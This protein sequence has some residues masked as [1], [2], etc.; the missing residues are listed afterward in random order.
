MN[1]DLQR[2]HFLWD[3][4]RSNACTSDEMDELL[5]ILQQPW[6]QAALD[7]RLYAQ[8]QHADNATVENEPDWEKMLSEIRTIKSNRAKR[9]LSIHWRYAAV[10]SLLII[11][12]AVSYMYR[13]HTIQP[14][15]ANDTLITVKAAPNSVDTLTLPDGSTA[16]LN[17][18]TTIRYRKDFVQQTRDL[19]VDGEVF[20]D[21]M[22]SKEHA[23]VIHSNQLETTVHGTSFVVNSYAG[24]SQQ[25]VSVITGKVSVK[26]K[27]T[28]KEV[29]LLPNQQAFFEANS[30]S[31]IRKELADAKANL[32]WQEGIWVLEDIRLVDAVKQLDTKYGK[33]THIEDKQLEDCRVSAS[34]PK[35]SY[36]EVL[37][38]LSNV[39][40]SAVK[41]K[42][43]HKTLYGEGCPF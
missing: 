27:G 19:Y 18:G 14:D 23:F 41:E 20:L 8:W 31:L 25:E 10:A 6:A 24:V 37:T 32:R 40:N 16:V 2:L 1:K 7:E 21:V 17:A 26:V 5:E 3:K 38:I 12:L 39:T 28:D 42:D 36:D 4:Y 9:R 35:L 30:Q 34:L 29:F 15:R 43:G 13:Q 11:V 33:K 22:P